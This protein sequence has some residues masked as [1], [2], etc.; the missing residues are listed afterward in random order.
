M[1]CNRKS[2]ENLGDLI[3]KLYEMAMSNPFP[4]EWL[5]KCLGDYRIESLEELRETEWMKML[6]DAV[7]DELAGS[8]ASDT[9]GT[10]CVCRGGRPVSV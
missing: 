2:D 6:W 5:Q 3:Q 9:G 7:G 8:R 4:E 10:E 1:F